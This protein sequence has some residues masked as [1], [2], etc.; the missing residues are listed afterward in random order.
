[1]EL[2][3]QGRRRAPQ[4][5]Q[6]HRGA[7]SGIDYDGVQGREP[8]H[9]LLQHVRV[10]ARGAAR[11]LRR[12][13]PAVP[14]VGRARVRGR[15]AP[16]TATTPLYYRF[17][18]CDAANAMLCVVGVLAALVH[19]D[20]TGEG[21]ELW[22]SLLDGGAVARVRR[23]A[24]RRRHARA[25]ARRSTSGQHGFEPYYRLY[26]TQDGWIQIAALRARAVGRA[27]HDARRRPVDSTARRPRR[28]SSSAFRTKTAVS[29]TLQ[30]STTPACPTRSR[31]TPRAATACSSTPTT[32][33]SASSPTTSTRSW[34]RCASSAS[35]IDFSDT[36][37]APH[38]PAAASAR[39]R[40][41]I[42]A[43]LGL[44]EARMA[45]LKDRGVVNW[46]DESYAAAW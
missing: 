46:P 33:G 35:T 7:S 16:S 17:G 10:R 41:E 12:P 21:Q 27:V 42:L 2:V 38:R 20:R 36:P 32:S 45:E 37:R 4:H 24:A 5:D 6:G 15:C 11:P 44:D 31:S 18:M 8:R 13:R 3:R 9:H 25:R 40:R 29:W 22:T 43:W 30:R 39:T 23:D 26:E 34:A 19:R 28:S 1:M 14:G